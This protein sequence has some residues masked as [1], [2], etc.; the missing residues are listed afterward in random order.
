MKL[1]ALRACLM[2]HAGTVEETPFGPEALVY[3]VHGKMFALVAWQASPL[4]IT[5]KCEP[6]RALALRD[7]YAAIS[8]GYHMNKRHWNTVNLD[9]SVGAELLSALIEHSYDLVVQSL[10]RAM[11]DEPT[12]RDR[13]ARAST[14]PSAS[15]RSIFS[16]STTIV[17]QSQATMSCV[18][19]RLLR[20]RSTIFMACSARLRD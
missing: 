1:E 18:C 6:V 11:R 7:E 9:G 16:A 17:S 5:L 4:R 12:A 20:S 10:P 2:D 19:A 15:S 8:A 13:L 3:K 14:H